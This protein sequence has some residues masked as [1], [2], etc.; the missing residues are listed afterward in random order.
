[1]FEVIEGVR[2]YIDDV[3]IWGSS[4]AEHND[5]LNKVLSQVQQYGIQ[6]NRSKCEF[7]KSQVKFI[8]ELLKSEGIRPDPDR[9]V[10]I[11]NLARPDDKKSLPRIFGMVNF[12]SK[13][14]PNLSSNTTTLRT[15]LTN[16]VLWNWTTQHE[17]EWQYIK[18]IFFLNPDKKIKVV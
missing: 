3:G 6:L 14:I 1:M 9:V 10:A 5:R 11:D 4:Q 8:G 16:D 15:L 18:S 7:S 17:S 2:V 13:F 12:V